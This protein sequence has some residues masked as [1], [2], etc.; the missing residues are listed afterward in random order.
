[1]LSIPRVVVYSC[2]SLYSSTQRKIKSPYS[3]SNL[4][5]F[6]NELDFAYTR[7]VKTALRSL[8]LVLFLGAIGYWAAAGANRG[9]TI[10]S[11]PKTVH[12]DVTG[13]DGV[14]YEKKFVPGV[15]LL[16]LAIAVSAAFA[17]ASFFF[18]TKSNPKA[19]N[20]QQPENPT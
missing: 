9:W 12:D 16:A 17:G 6:Y 11:V 7:Q 13:L 15:E 19:S 1:M 4:P 8:A 3:H 18:R 14:T 20:A 2:F 10:N 5:Q